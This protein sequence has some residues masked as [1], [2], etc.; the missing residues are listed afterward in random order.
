MIKMMFCGGTD[1]I[2]DGSCLKISFETGLGSEEILVDA[3][4]Y[5]GGKSIRASRNYLPLPFN[6]KEVKRIFISH[7]HN[8]HSGRAP[9]YYNRGFRGIIH[10][11]G[12]TAQICEEA[13]LD[14]ARIQER[15]TERKNPIRQSLGM[16]PLWPLFNRQD[17]EETL[18]L[19][20]TIENGQERQF[21]QWLTAKLS[22][23]AHILGS[24][25]IELDIRDKHGKRLRI[26]YAVDLGRENPFHGSPAQVK[27]AD[28]LII[29]ST[30]GGR[31]HSENAQNHDFLDQ[32]A[33]TVSNNGNVIMPTFAL[34]LP[35]ILYDIYKEQQ[36]GSWAGEILKKAPIFIHTPLGVKMLNIHRQN[37]THLQ[38]E[39][40]SLFEKGK[41]PL[42]LPNMRIVSDSKALLDIR[43]A[44]II[45]TGGMADYG[46]VVSYIKQHATDSSNLI[47]FTGYQDRGTRGYEMVNGAKTINFGEESVPVMARVIMT[48]KYST[49]ADYQD[50]LNWIKG[51]E[52]V[53]K[54]IFIV[55]GETEQANYLAGLIKEEF[56]ETRVVI[57]QL[58][59]TYTVNDGKVIPSS[60][61]ADRIIIR[62]LDTAI[63]RLRVRIESLTEMLDNS[64]M[65]EP[66]SLARFYQLLSFLK[67]KEGRIKLKMKKKKNR[68]NAI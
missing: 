68:K 66:K 28:V 19:F 37:F 54:V 59:R 56:R 13:F 32:A 23:S 45:A 11:T 60:I 17:A 29:D 51:F 49:H 44:V 53:P 62:G 12:L 5:H 14:G 21:S 50:M 40:R 58:Y 61:E 43:G 10:A 22:S 27:D 3:G 36:S 16:Q 41:D 9:E 20:N 2:I 55:H 34:R 30:Y 26:C 33:R 42:S 31:L 6:P 7:G 35:N 15:N 48:N 1:G 64:G 38:P 57:P 67:E 46:P 8:D 63:S 25:I 24:S 65:N 18:N 52:Q 39:I 47:C 4:N